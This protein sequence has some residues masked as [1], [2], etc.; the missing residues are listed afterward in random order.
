MDLSKLKKR[1]F[2]PVCFCL[3]L[4][5]LLLC[6]SCG[7][8]EDPESDSSETG[9]TQEVRDLV[10]KDGSF[11]EEEPEDSEDVKQETQE[12]AP[13]AQ[14]KSLDDLKSIL[15]PELTA[16]T[17]Q[18]ASVSVYVENLSDGSM[19]TLDSRPMQAASLIKLYVAGCVFEQSDLVR[20]QETYTGE[21]DDLMASMIT[22]SDN[23]AANTLTTRLGQGDPA[24]GM[25]LVNQYCQTHGFTDTHMGRLMLAPNDYDD[26][27]TSVNDCGAF[28]K[29]I[30]EG[31]LEGS[32]SILEL[33]KQQER[34][35]KIPAGIPEGIL[36]AN[37]TGELTDVENDAALVYPANTT[38]TICVMTE[39][40]SDTYSARCMITDISSLT[41]NYMCAQN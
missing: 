15:E 23:N 33:M 34:T 40:L 4:T 26:N 28:L 24:A 38:Y 29:A 2:R 1:L 12:P 36:T 8:N 32:A 30:Q 11:P 22:V 9:S 10:I 21:T 37:K 13:E 39:G 25:A 16:V 18:D 17:S 31:R 35:E 6:V 27:Y 5:V 20:R 14:V 19:L 41:Y 3:A 7:R